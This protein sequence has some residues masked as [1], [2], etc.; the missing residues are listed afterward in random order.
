MLHIISIYRSSIFIDIGVHTLLKKNRRYDST[1]SIG[2]FGLPSARAS[3]W[4]PSMNC[5]RPMDLMPFER[6]MELA[7]RSGRSLFTTKLNF[8]KLRRERECVCVCLCYVFSF[9]FFLHSYLLQIPHFFSVFSLYN[10]CNLLSLPLSLS[11]SFRSSLSSRTAFGSTRRSISQQS[12]QSRAA[13]STR[14][15]FQFQLRFQNIAAFFLWRTV[16][17]GRFQLNSEFAVRVFGF[18]VCFACH[19]GR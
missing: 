18:C 16:I 11:L 7:T 4:R 1:S 17:V 8:Q 13:Q 14:A 6:W 9:S 3:S 15:V 5:D 12:Q 19:G 2:S 10:L